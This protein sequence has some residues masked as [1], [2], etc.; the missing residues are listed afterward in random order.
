MPGQLVHRWETWK[1]KKKSF[2]LLLTSNRTWRGK[3]T[4]SQT[5]FPIQHDFIIT[6]SS[7]PHSWNLF[8]ILA[9]PMFLLHQYVQV[10]CKCKITHPKKWKPKFT[11]LQSQIHWRINVESHKKINIIIINNIISM[12]IIDSSFNWNVSPF[13]SNQCTQQIIYHNKLLSHE[14]KLRKRKKKKKNQQLLNNN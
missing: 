6:K 3:R 9:D 7:V 13:N 2:W 11:Y 12:S 5:N 8:F 1:A 4:T 10:L 14:I